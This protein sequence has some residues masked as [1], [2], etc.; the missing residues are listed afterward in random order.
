LEDQL[1]K[2]DNQSKFAEAQ[3]T[4]QQIE[5][6]LKLQKEKTLEHKRYLHEEEVFS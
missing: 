3:I 1:H 6:L 5:Y 4:K 2:L